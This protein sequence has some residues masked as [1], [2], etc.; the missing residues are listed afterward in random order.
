MTKKNIIV[1]SISLLMLVV[2]LFV[3]Y[4]NNFFSKKN[5]D[6]NLENPINLNEENI[7][8]LSDNNSDDIKSSNEGEISDEACIE[9]TAYLSLIAESSVYSE[10]IKAAIALQ[11]GSKLEE[12][13]NRYAKRL[14]ELEEEYGVDSGS[15]Y[16][17]EYCGNRILDDAIYERVKERMIEL[18]SEIE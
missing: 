7:G 18:G 17:I 15:D 6:Y 2:L 1:I 11:D 8:G 16:F 5:I 9:I 3:A 13:E 10:A 4:Q 14:G 12:I